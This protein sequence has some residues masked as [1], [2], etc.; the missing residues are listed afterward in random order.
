MSLLRSC[1]GD[2]KT[3]FGRSSNLTAA[4]AALHVKLGERFHQRGLDR[5]SFFTAVFTAGDRFLGAFHSRFRGGFIDLFLFDGHV[6]QNVDAFLG[7]LDKSLA[8]REVKRLVSFCHDQLARLNLRHHRHVHRQ[9]SHLTFDSRNYDHV[10]VVAVG[11][12]FGSDD[13]Q[14]EGSHSVGRICGAEERR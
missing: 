7:Y 2:P 6:R 3:V 11:A 12:A 4:P 14:S 8:D 13:F 5:G 10:D 9:N 1:H